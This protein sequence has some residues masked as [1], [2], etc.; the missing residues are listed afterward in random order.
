MSSRNIIELF[1]AVGTSIYKNDTARMEKLG[2]IMRCGLTPT[3]IMHLTGDF[4]EWSNEAAFYGASIIAHQLNISLEELKHEVFENMK[5]KLYLNIVKLLLEKDG[6]HLLN[7]GITSQLNDLL[8]LSF[9]K[10]RAFI[11]NGAKKNDFMQCSFTTKAKLV[12]IG[13]PIHIFLP[14]VSRCLNAE[15]V[16]PENAG[17]ANAIGAIIGNVSVE[18]TVVIRPRTTAVIGVTGYY[19]YSSYE[20]MEFPRYQDALAW[21]KKHAE[22]I[23]CRI[24]EE[25]GAGSIE[26]AVEVFTNEVELLTDYGTS[27]S[28]SA[29]IKAH[30][31]LFI[32]TIVTCR[33][34]GKIKWIRN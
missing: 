27:D 19:C 31:K 29:A 15:Y 5:E 1:D 28:E 24:S 21:G 13:A 18:E 7:N 32:E 10:S 11:R 33:A 6:S 23:A 9:K 3:D 17:V 8:I 12:G 22:S 20:N 34:T 26:T 16:I 4:C 2:I 14:D 25:R 30:G